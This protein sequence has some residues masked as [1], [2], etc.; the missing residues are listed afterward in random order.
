MCVPIQLRTTTLEKLFFQWF[1][2]DFLDA[3]EL[4][5]ETKF[6]LRR[7]RTSGAWPEQLNDIIVR[8]SATEHLLW[9]FDE[10]CPHWNMKMKEK[11]VSS[12]LSFFFSFHRHFLELEKISIPTR[13]WVTAFFSC[14]DNQNRPSEQIGSTVI[15]TH[16]L[17]LFSARENFC[18]SEMLIFDMEKL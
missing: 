14:V 17:E 8:R 11:N 18:G 5:R 10:F 9:M 13:Y 16:R 3:N 6:R 12:S 7:S 1:S 15:F 2:S 4:A